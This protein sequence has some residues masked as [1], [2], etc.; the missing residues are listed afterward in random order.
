VFEWLNTELEAIRVEGKEDEDVEEKKR[1]NES[2]NSIETV[3]PFDTSER[4]SE[5]ERRNN[6]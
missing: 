4:T 6:R 2:N 1:V 3:V 5:R